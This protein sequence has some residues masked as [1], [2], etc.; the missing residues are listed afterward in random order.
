MWE[1]AVSAGYRGHD[2]LTDDAVETE[3]EARS[4]ALSAAQPTHG[5]GVMGGLGV[6]PGPL[7]S[8][9]KTV[10]VSGAEV[11]HGAVY[12]EGY[13]GPPPGHDAL[14]RFAELV[15]DPTVSYTGIEARSAALSAAQPTHGEGVMGGLGVDPGP[16]SSSGKTVYVS[17]AE[18][19]HGAVYGERYADQHNRQPIT[20]PGESF[21]PGY[22]LARAAQDGRITG[23][24]EWAD[25]GLS[26]L[27]FLPA[28]KLLKPASTVLR[29]SGRLTLP[30]GAGGGYLPGTTP[31]SSVPSLKGPATSQ[32][33][34]DA[35]LEARRQLAATGQA[36]VNV[37]GRTYTFQGDRLDESLRRANPDAPAISYTAAPNVD[38]FAEGGP[39]P[40]LQFPPDGRIAAGQVSEIGGALPAHVRAALAQPPN[41]RAGTVKPASEQYQFRSV[42]G[43]VPK[44]SQ[45][46]A[47]GQTGTSPG[48]VAYASRLDE[49]EV[50]GSPSQPLGVNYYHGRELELGA[51]TGT[52][53]PA[54]SA[55]A[56][57]GPTFGTRL[58]LPEGVNLPGFGE[59]TRANFLTLMDTARRR[60]LA[61]SETA[62]VD[63]VARAKFNQDYSDLTPKQARQV[64][65]ARMSDD[66]LSAVARATARTR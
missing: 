27:D 22:D 33:V 18:V 5:E 42:G 46:S 23:V 64:D 60:R 37:G 31:F 17:G 12:G 36:Q 51:A 28:T 30:P 40:T 43:P 13:T 61:S 52:E 59:R 58:Y 38:V 44:F 29:T 8:S 3:I 56:G 66:Q 34:V 62:S 21:V 48:L 14:D 7:S 25:V 63:D 24:G 19:G 35:S 1:G 41:P 32:E 50:P 15:P 20:L 49:L 26:A 16:L 4:A 47:F 55:A 65:V 54:V 53:L 45:A 6:D 10:Y 39:V 57:A 9:G 11:G 2:R